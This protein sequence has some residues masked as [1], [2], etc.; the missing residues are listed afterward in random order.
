[1]MARPSRTQP[2]CHS[3]LN[4]CFVPSDAILVTSTSQAPTNCPKS[5]RC[6]ARS[7]WGPC[8]CRASIIESVSILAPYAC[9]IKP[10]PIYQHGA[11]QASPIGIKLREERK[12]T[13]GSLCHHEAKHR[14]TNPDGGAMN[15]VTP[16]S[17]IVRQILEEAANV[18]AKESG[19]PQRARVLS[20]ADFAQTL[21]FGWLS[22]PE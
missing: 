21:I 14:A 4:S 19:F 8:A 5:M 3:P 18:L 11:M 2:K 6:S 10:T 7:G 20:G 9:A 15:S 22:E 1:M 17:E 16:L 13:K 12:T